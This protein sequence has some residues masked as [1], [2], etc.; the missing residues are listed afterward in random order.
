MHYISK[1]PMFGFT[2]FMN[3]NIATSIK[4]RINH[5]PGR[6]VW[7]RNGLRL[8]Y[9]ILARMPAS[10]ATDVWITVSEW[11]QWVDYNTLSFTWYNRINACSYDGDVILVNGT[12]PHEGRVELCSRS[13]W[14]TACLCWLVENLRLWGKSYLCT[15]ALPSRRYYNCTWW[16]ATDWRNTES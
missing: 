12:G 8:W 1:H 10:T 13:I 9:L 16:R 14:K 15:T 7:F 3:S 6:H 11:I 5:I 4:S 2:E